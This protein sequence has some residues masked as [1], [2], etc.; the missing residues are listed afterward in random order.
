MHQTSCTAIGIDLGKNTFHLIDLDD[1]GATVLRLKVSRGQLERR[2]ANVPQCLIGMEACAGA[3]HVGR[4]LAALGHDVRLMPAKY[5]KPF[6]KGHK[7]DHRDAEAIAEAVGRAT[8]RFVPLKSS[9]QLDLQALHRVRSRLIGQRTAVINQIRGFLLE[10]GIPVRQGAASL[11]RA[12]PDILATR[13]DVLSSRLVRLIQD[14]ADDWRRLDARI[15]D[16]TS[17]ISAVAAQDANCHRLMS[18]PGIGS[19]TASAMVAAIADGSA[20]TRGRDFAAWL[21]LVPKQLSTGDRTILGRISKRGN[22]Y[23]RTLFIQGARAALL[24]PGSWAKHG[25]GE[26]LEAAARRLHRNVL[27]VA[28]ANK[29]ARIAWAVL[30]GKG[31]YEADF[32]TQTA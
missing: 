27:A 32:E 6:L 5:V 25:L 8:M 15:D 10:C 30:A 11:R 19:I 22:R 14:L 28:L 1:R 20:F 26:W 24:R 9:E 31:G 17:E 4:R 13:S 2:L 7:N 29:L 21:G 16:V 12:L 3:H 18:A 23:L